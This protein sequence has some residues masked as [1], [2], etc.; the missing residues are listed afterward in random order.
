MIEWVLVLLLLLAAESRSTQSP[1]P[2]TRLRHSTATAQAHRLRQP[3][4]PFREFSVARQWIEEAL[5]AI[6]QAQARPPVHAR[7]LLTVSIALFNA[8]AS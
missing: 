8:W 7:N 2:P 6:R 1:P 4:L 3:T 5:L